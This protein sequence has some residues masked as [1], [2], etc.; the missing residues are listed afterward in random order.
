VRNDCTLNV[1]GG[2]RRGVVIYTVTAAGNDVFGAVT[3]ETA[4]EA[5]CAR[6]ASNL[7]MYFSRPAQL[8]IVN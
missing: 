2:G 8:G 4:C 3:E 7:Y 5:A 6:E 1:K